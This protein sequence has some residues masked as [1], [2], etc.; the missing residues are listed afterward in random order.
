MDEYVLLRPG[1]SKISLALQGGA[2][3]AV[4]A[5]VAVVLASYVSFDNEKSAETVTAGVL[6]D[7]KETAASAEPPAP[8]VPLKDIER[9]LVAESGD[10]LM[11]MFTNASISRADAYQAITAMREVFNPRDLRPGHTITASFRP[12]GRDSEDREFLGFVFEPE[13]GQII[14]VLRNEEGG[15]SAKRKDP[16]L[17]LSVAHIGGTIR[18]NLYGDGVKAGLPP[19]A[20]VEMIRLF[21][22]DIDFQRDVHPGDSF[23]VMIE[24]SRLKNGRIAE[25]GDMLYAEITLSGTTRRFYRFETKDS[26]GR[27]SVDYYDEKGRSARKALL[28]T[29]ID[30]ARLSSGFG[31]RR[32]PILGYTRMHRGVDFAAPSGT[33]IYAAGNGTVEFA[34]RNGGYGRYIRIRHTK[35]YATAYAHMRRFARGIQQGSRVKQGQVIGYVGSTGRSTGPHLHYEV[36]SKGAQVNPLRLRLPS[37]RNLAGKELKTF[38]S[39]RVSLDRRYAKLSTDT[40]VTSR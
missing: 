17:E 14:S 30:G 28:K 33:P 9:T 26:R 4:V 22:W 34:G 27:S 24:Q 35:E 23:G 32:H 11:S 7:A 31:K 5:T 20:L 18:S 37:G 1:S 6:T 12:A 38:D 2:L 25:W 10:T 13:I 16:K 8:V 3:C 36:L 39:V 19:A 15:F 40:Q 29:P 21:S